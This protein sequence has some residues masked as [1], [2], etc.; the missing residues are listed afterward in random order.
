M[1]MYEY[2]YTIYVYMITSNTCLDLIVHSLHMLIYLPFAVLANPVLIINAQLISPA[3]PLPAL[4]CTVTTLLA[5]ASNQ[6]LALSAKPTMVSRGGV[7]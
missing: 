7:L 5:S 2:S 4:Q 1:C 6:S 3:L